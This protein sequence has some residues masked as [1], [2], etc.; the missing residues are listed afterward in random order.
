MI[1][2]YN[3]HHLFP[4]KKENHIKSKSEKQ[5]ITDCVKNSC[6]WEYF[7]GVDALLVAAVITWRAQNG[8]HS[9]Y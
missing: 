7:I 4:E 8:I 1:A 3:Q 2:T 5:E 6:H 9:N